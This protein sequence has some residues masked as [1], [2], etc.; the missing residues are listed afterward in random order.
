L[1]QEQVGLPL[2]EQL[3]QLVQQELLARQG[4]L[5]QLVQQVAPEALA[6]VMD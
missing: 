5:V 6:S 4:Q 2:L 1:G 3:G